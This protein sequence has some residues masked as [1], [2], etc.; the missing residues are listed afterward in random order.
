MSMFFLIARVVRTAYK[1]LRAAAG[2]LIVGHAVY[3][4]VKTKRE[5]KKRL[6]AA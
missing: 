6:V 5:G 4:W 3:R 1:A 2:I